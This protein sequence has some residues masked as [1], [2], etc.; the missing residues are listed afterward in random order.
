MTRT[1]L[2]PIGTRAE[3]FL[4]MTYNVLLAS[5]EQVPCSSESTSCASFKHRSTST[6][7][8]KSFCF[9]YSS[10]KAS[11]FSR[12]SIRAFKSASRSRNTLSF[13]ASLFCLLASLLFFQ[14]FIAS[15]QVL[16]LV[17]QSRLKAHEKE[18]K[19]EKKASREAEEAGGKWRKF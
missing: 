6:R 1:G 18:L 16:G 11:H 3:D 8:T 15:F 10:M 7:A 12:F 2:K 14:L 4:P 13:S 5:V 9:R 17:V 19:E